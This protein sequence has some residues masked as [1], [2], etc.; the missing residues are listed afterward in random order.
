MYVETVIDATIILRNMAM[1]EVQG[2]V[3]LPSWFVL[4]SADW[5]YLSQCSL[6]SLR[7]SGWNQLVFVAKN[8]IP[9]VYYFK[10]LKMLVSSYFRTRRNV[11][12]NLIG[13]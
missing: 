4:S 13:L 10:F 7:Y 1:V 11:Y 12:I 5:Q 9:T 3:V 8:E 6:L 2:L